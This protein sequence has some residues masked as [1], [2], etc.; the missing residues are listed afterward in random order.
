MGISATELTRGRLP[1]D[2]MLFRADGTLAV[3]DVRLTGGRNP[4]VSVARFTVEKECGALSPRS[5]AD[6]RYGVL[7]RHV[8]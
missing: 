2:L 6:G 1:N 3:T 4:A 8:R 5:A 7:G